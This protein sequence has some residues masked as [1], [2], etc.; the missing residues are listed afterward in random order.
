[1]PKLKLK[2]TPAEERERELRK[3]RRAA[4]RAAKLGAAAHAHIRRQTSGAT[5]TSYI[6]DIPENVHSYAGESDSEYGPHPAEADASTTGTDYSHILEE[7][8]E[9]RFREKLT[10]AM[11]ADAFDDTTYVER[12]DSVEA[13]L[14]EYAHMPRRWRTGGMQHMER[15]HDDGVE[16]TDPS[17]LE[18]EEYAEWV[19]HGMWRCV[20]SQS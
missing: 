20:A 3:S 14:S 5:D 11:D 2:R 18:D 17:M 1:M 7:L 9:R 4:K 6:F 12:L 13:S 16:V 19:R 10:D 15:T 8:D